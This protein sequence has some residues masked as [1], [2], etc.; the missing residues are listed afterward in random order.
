[1]RRRLRR[2]NVRTCLG[3]RR[4]GS[5]LQFLAYNSISSNGDALVNE[6]LRSS[7]RVCTS[8]LSTIRTSDRHINAANSHPSLTLLISNLRTRHR[9]KVAVSITCHC[10]S[11]RG[12]GFVVTSA[13][14]RRRC[15]Q[16][17][18]ANTSAYGI[19]IVL[20][21]THGKIL[22]RAHHR[23]CV[24]GLLN[25]HRFM[26]TMGGVSLISC[27]RSHFRRVGRRCLAF[28]GGLGGP[29]LR[30]SVLPLS[31]LRKSGMMGRDRRLS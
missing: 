29:G 23:S 14:K 1:M 3:R 22:S 17:V 19:T 16:G 18:T 26:I 2:L 9:R 20:V 24:T 4:C 15:A 28:S 21:S 11:A 31:T 8:R 10:F 12:H 7:G 25:V 6:L 13:P 5:L 30:V 27:S